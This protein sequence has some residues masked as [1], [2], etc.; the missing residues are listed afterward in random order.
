MKN[1][2]KFLVYTFSAIL[3]SLFVIVG[4]SNN[5][6]TFE[7]NEGRE[8]TVTTNIGE[9][10][11]EIKF[12]PVSNF[13]EFDLYYDGI[14]YSLYGIRHGMGSNTTYFLDAQDKHIV[15]PKNS[16]ISSSVPVILT[17]SKVTKTKTGVVVSLDARNNPAYIRQFD[18]NNYLGSYYAPHSGVQYT[19]YK[20]GDEL[21]VQSS[22]KDSPHFESGKLEK[23]GYRRY[24]RSWTSA[25][26]KSATIFSFN[27][28][29]EG[30]K[31]VNVMN[32]AIG[33]ASE[34]FLLHER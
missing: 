28:I 4:Y 27:T 32:D 22:T 10:S 33:H 24:K 8:K 6:L 5:D 14:Y 12:S 23:I 15:P 16:N 3:M 11:L 34:G 18:V 1:S 31:R 26:G 13:H 2:S 17:L 25:L 19:F 9:S 7:L 20:E 29:F 30:R 21:F